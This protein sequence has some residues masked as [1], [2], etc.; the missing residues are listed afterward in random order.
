M[1]AK[2][3]HFRNA[4]FTLV[5]LMVAVGLFG[6]FSV[7]M[8][9]TWMFLQNTSISVA[10]YTTRQSDQMRA[11]DYL[12]RDIRRAASVAIYNGASLVSGT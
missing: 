4:G 3:R 8:I 1:S 11:V 7:A 9:T 12:K 5:E 10:A 2:P 6:F